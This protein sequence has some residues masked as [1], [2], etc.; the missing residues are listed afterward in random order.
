MAMDP[1]SYISLIRDGGSVAVIVIV[2]I[3]LGRGTL[4]LGRE[5]ADKE[6]QLRKVEA[7]RDRWQRIAT[8]ALGLTHRVTSVLEERDPR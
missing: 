6:A 2:G 1:S 3:L 7:D 5:V 8:D 4:R